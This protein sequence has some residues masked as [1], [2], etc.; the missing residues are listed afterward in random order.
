MGR[1]GF[2]SSEM[3]LTQG[4]IP[5]Q[6]FALWLPIVLGLLVQSL[7]T[8]AD[9]AVVGRVV[10]DTAL[11][12]VGCSTNVSNFLLFVFSGIGTGAGVVISQY[13]GAKQEGKLKNAVHGSIFLSLVV[14]VVTAA[15]GIFLT[16]PMLVWLNTPEHDGTLR[17]AVTYMR[18]LL[19]GLPATAL[20]NLTGG[21]L[22]AVG[23]S[24]T[25][26]YFLLIASIMNIILD[27][28]FVAGFQWG[29]GG[30]AFATIIA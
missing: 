19:L 10:G 15:A 1:S 7:Y 13:F 4:S 28:L 9:S 20:Y 5:K 14:S 6:L 17:L 18:V 24:R 27:I 12:A 26:F 11:A 8:M 2:R 25:P 16:G 22:R 3:D 30:A 29:V 21:V 23:D